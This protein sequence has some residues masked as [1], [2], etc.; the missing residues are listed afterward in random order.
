[1]LEEKLLI[2]SKKQHN[3]LFDLLSSAMLSYFVKI[4]Y[5]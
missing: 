4:N 1:M 3:L 2:Q 5:G